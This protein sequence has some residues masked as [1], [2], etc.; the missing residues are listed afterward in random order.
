MSA[1]I[2]SNGKELNH[3]CG[4][5]E[6]PSLF[7]IQQLVTKGANIEWESTEEGSYTALMYSCYYGYAPITNYLISKKA[8][9][10]KRDGSYGDTALHWACSNGHTECAIL[11]IEAGADY[12]LMNKWKE[13]PLDKATTPEVREAI[14]KAIDAHKKR[15]AST[16]KSRSEIASSELIRAERLPQD[17]TY[18][19]EIETLEATV[20]LAGSVKSS[21]KNEQRVAL[22]RV[23]SR[24]S[25]LRIARMVKE[26]QNGSDEF[27]TDVITAL[28][29]IK[30][31]RKTASEGEAALVKIQKQHTNLGRPAS[32]AFSPTDGKRFTLKELQA[33]V[34]N[35][36][37]TDKELYLTDPDFLKHFS[38]TKVA[39]KKLPKWKQQGAKSKLQI[40]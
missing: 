2:N 19:T 22:A 8:D 16:R 39:F 35:I 28:L 26:A 30:S 13:T 18:S 20:A 37:D 21:L 29:S 33:G 24:L 3:L 6:E 40:F 34:E 7:Q 14:Q 17:V 9:L 32:A 12:K 31:A 5:D 4:T 25:N 36:S 23:E 1:L 10:H 38:M 15:L 11:L 27:L